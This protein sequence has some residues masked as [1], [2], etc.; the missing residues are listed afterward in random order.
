MLHALIFVCNQRL[1]LPIKAGQLYVYILH[2]SHGRHCKLNILFI[3]RIKVL[4]EMKV[5]LG[6]WQYTSIGDFHF[7]NWHYTF[8][9]PS[10]LWFDKFT[11]MILFCLQLMKRMFFFST[12][13]YIHSEMKPSSNSIFKTI[14]N[15]C[16][17]TAFTL[18]HLVAP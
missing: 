7:D 10:G 6:L 4:F 1:V 5:S 11:N 8:T 18:V 17:L 12:I 3:I 13:L 2:T 9:G 16:F 14:C 15:L